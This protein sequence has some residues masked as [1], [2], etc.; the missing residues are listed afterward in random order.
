MRDSDAADPGRRRQTVRAVRRLPLPGPGSLARIR[1]RDPRSG[2]NDA[3]FIYIR[4]GVPKRAKMYF[5]CKKD[6]EMFASSEK[7]ATFA[8]AFEK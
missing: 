5:S 1:G 7:V 4:Y 8:S 2:S 3:I 6:A